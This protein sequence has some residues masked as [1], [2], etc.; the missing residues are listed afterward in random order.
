MAEPYDVYRDA[1]EAEL[2]RLLTADSPAVAPL[3]GMLRYHLGWCDAE[4]APC[5]SRAGKR[6]R[7]IISLLCCQALGGNWSQ[8]LPY[9]A[10]I[11]LVHNFSLIHDDIEDQSDTR[12]ERATVWNVWG[13]A[14]GINAGDAMWSLARAAMLELRAGHPAETVLAA[15]ALLDRTCLQLCAGQYLDISFEARQVV[16]LAEYEE[17][18]RGKTAALLAATCQGGALLAGADAARQATLAAFGQ[19]LGLTYQIVDDLL[20]IWGKA[21]VTG[22]SAES[23]I[24]AR[25]KTFPVAYAMQW[26]A[27]RGS[28]EL[29]RAY[30]SPSS[31][32]TD[33]QVLALLQRAGAREHTQY[34]ARQ[35]H[36]AMLQHL[37]A[38]C[39][40]GAAGELLTKLVAD[41]ATRAY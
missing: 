31:P 34:C 26:E 5:L 4:F 32:E 10:A 30:V 36:Q 6:L 28:A 35:H 8:A 2:Q 27:E 41:L 9:A 25:K 14:H 19:E 17:M 21:S 12:H 33:A 15:V 16:S 38:A 40:S 20:G 23:D 13:L 7:P 1:I 37:D 39:L 29:Q 24:A 18:A 11:E 3:Y 22:K